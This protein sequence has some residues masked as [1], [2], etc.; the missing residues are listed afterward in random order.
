MDDV[1]RRQAE[2]GRDSRL[3]G[4]ATHA[5]TLLRQAKAGGEQ[6]RTSGAMDRAIDAPASEQR[7]IRR[8]DDRVD[9]AIHR[10][11]G[12]ELL[13]AC[14]ALPEV[15]PGVRCPTA[16]ARITPGFDLP[17]R[18]VIHTVGPVWHGGGQDEAALLAACY[19]NS[20]ALAREHGV[21]TLALPCI[22]TGV[23]GFPPELAA[24]IAVRTVRE[25]GAGFDAI[26]FCCFSATDL[27]L[28]DIAL[29]DGK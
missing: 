12:P 24:P 8:V 19:R 6:F 14:R 18:F 29:A 21:R 11:A 26:T 1:A 27:A 4:R 15:R 28:Y 7:L 20:L 5:G 9:G 3:A 23:Y 10:A 13:A 17:A 16:E 22:S 2:P 25:H